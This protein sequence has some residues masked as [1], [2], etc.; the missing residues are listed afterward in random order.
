MD[1]YLHTAIATGC[2]AAAYYL[3]K[4]QGLHAGIHATIV[5]LGAIGVIK[6]IYDSDDNIEDIQPIGEDKN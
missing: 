5:G 1:P 3:G 2:I 6:L 4:H